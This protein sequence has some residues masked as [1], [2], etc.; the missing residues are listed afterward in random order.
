MT[1]SIVARDPSSGEFGVAVQSHYFSVGPAVPWAQP[2]V[3]AVAT[4]SMVEVSFGPRGLALMAAGKSAQ[5]ALDQLLADDPGR[6]SRQVALVD[7]EW[8]SSIGR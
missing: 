5:T 7:G 1:Y 3:G 4:Q 6:E 8:L 2:G